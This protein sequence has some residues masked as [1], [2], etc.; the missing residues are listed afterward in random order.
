M[1]LA[2]L[3]SWFPQPPNNG[4][5]L[6]AAHLI[7]ELSRR[8]EISLLTFAEP[9]EAQEADLDKL[10]SICANVRV[11]PG[12]PHKPH[13]GLSWRGLFGQMPR[14][15]AQT[16]N[17][18]MASYVV[19]A[20]ARADA[21]VAFQI[22]TAVYFDRLQHVPLVFDEA[23]A[24]VI[25]DGQSPQPGNALK[26]WRRRMTWR[27]YAAYTKH[28]ITAASKTTVVS[29]AERKCLGEAGCDTSRIAI[30]PNGVARDYLTF[31]E[32]KRP[33]TLIY[34]GSLTYAPNF[35]AAEYFLNDI[36]PQV[37]AARPDASMTITG[38]YSGVPIQRLPPAKVILTGLVPDIRPLVARSEVCVVPLRLGGG[39]RLKILEAMALGTPVVSTSKGAEGLDVT[40]GEHI[41]IADDPATFA[42]YVI[43]LL[44]NPERARQLAASARSLV[45]WRYTWQRIG[46]QLEQVLQEAVEAERASRRN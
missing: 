45:S 24:S 26:Q 4:A 34:P 23:D 18:R 32:P 9:G 1:R 11:V 43:E 44:A 41:M 40:H 5:K 22:G 10:R 13:G 46:L 6:R 28:L 17:P 14:S 29:E 8:H 35:D 3:S 42:R 7:E 33:G 12:N 38:S 19:D 2:V 16:Y 39:T 31:D 20:A 36:F 27:K 15:Y 37:R 30:V 21:M 25:R